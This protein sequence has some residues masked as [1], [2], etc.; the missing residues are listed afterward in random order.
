MVVRG[1]LEDGTLAMVGDGFTQ[2][3]CSPWRFS[4]QTDPRERPQDRLVWDAL[5]RR[6]A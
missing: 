3:Y 1:S 6:A 4:P 2:G 5:T